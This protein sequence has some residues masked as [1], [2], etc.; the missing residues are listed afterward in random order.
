MERVVLESLRAHNPERELG[1][2]EIFLF[3]FAVTY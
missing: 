1:T 2:E 3:G